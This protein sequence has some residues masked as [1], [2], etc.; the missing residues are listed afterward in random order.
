MQELE[1][2]TL[3]AVQNPSITYSQALCIC[4]SYLWLQGSCN[5]SVRELKQETT[6]KWTH[7]VQICVIQGS[8]VFVL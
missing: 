4:G 5:T 8:T 1:A 6:Y 7:A 3:W 2:L